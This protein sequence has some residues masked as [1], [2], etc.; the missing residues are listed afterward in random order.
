[1]KM[2]KEQY[3]IFMHALCFFTRVPPYKMIYKEE[4]EGELLRYFTLIGLFIGLTHSLF[5]FSFFLFFYL[6]R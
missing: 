6:G 3:N 4:H 5:L 1:M 2:I